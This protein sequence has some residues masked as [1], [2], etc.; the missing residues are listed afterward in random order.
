MSGTVDRRRRIPDAS[1]YV[2]LVGIVVLMTALN[3]DRFPTLSNLQ[4]MASQLPILAFLS[5]GVMISMLSGGINL[6]IVSTANFTG[7][8]TALMLRL[9]TDGNSGDATLGITVI[10]MAVGVAGCLLVGAFMGGWWPTS[11]CHRSW[12]R[13]A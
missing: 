8:V 6:A 4:S 7:I 1:L 5:I 9:L 3:P 10:A 13:S 12:R 2:I 11:K